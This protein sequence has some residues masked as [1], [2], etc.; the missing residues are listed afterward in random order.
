MVAI[1]AIAAAPAAATCHSAAGVSI[2]APRMCFIIIVY[3]FCVCHCFMCLFYCLVVYSGSESLHQGSGANAWNAR[4]N[5]KIQS[6]NE[7]M[8]ASEV[9]A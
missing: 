8:S 9:V 6:I 2:P 1:T 5:S 3:V 7:Q 4:P